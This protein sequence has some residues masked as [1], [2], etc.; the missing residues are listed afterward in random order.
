M[1]IHHHIAAGIDLGSNTFRLLIADCSNSSLKVLIKKQATVRL[2]RSLRTN[3]Q[4]LPDAMQKGFNVLRAFRQTLDRY[5]PQS[6]RVCGT[7]AL[8]QAGNSMIFLQ[9]AEKI[10]QHPVHLIS[11]TEEAC[12]SLAGALSGS[13]QIFNPPL[14][15][16]DV[17]GG[18]TELIFAESLNG[19]IRT[20]SIELGVVWLTESFITEPQHDLASLENVITEVLKTAL[21]DL[22]ILSKKQQISI[23]G[24][25]GTAT[26]MAALQQKLS[27]YDESLVHGYIL[28]GPDIEK[29]FER[30][31]AMAAEKRNKLPCLGEER[32]EILPAGMR[33]YCILLKLLRQNRMQISD[34]GLLEGILLSSISD[35]N[36]PD[37]IHFDFSL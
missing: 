13:K 34:T 11:G 25:G 19:D 31:I 9:K 23:I 27:S 22:R 36:R 26:S 8:R 17:G 7:E 29:L 6:I 37:R 21:E 2:G 28:Q 30:L 16:V 24:G 10:M 4:M 18:S 33:I 5:Q 14:L 12:L 35:P 1:T 15:L 20:A 32:G 3:G